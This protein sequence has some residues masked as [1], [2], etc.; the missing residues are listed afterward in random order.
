[1]SEN[2]KRSAMDRTM[3]PGKV[4]KLTSALLLLSL[5][6]LLFSACYGGANTSSGSKM[7]KF[8]IV[9]L[10]DTQVYS[11]KY[12]EIFA[13]QTQWIVEHKDEMN[14]AF[15][16][17]E[18]DIVN[19]NT[20]AE[21]ENA[22]DAMMLLDGV[23]P[24]ALAVGNHDMGTRGVA[25]SRDTTLF[26][27][28][29]PLSR[30]SALPTFGGVFEEDKMDNCYHLFIA[31]GAD[32]LILALEFGPRDQVLEWANNVMA[33]HRDRRAIILT[34]AY[35]YNDNTLHGSKTDH[36]WTPSS[37]GITNLPGGA[38]NGVGIWNKLVSQHKNINFVFSGHVLNSGVGRLVSIG[39][40]GNKIYQMLANY[41][42]IKNGGNGYLRIVEFDPAN[43]E[44]R[45]KTYS[46]LL[47]QYFK[48]D[49]ILSPHLDKYLKLDNF[50]DDAHEF[51]FKNW[52]QA[53]EDETLPFQNYSLSF[54]ERAAD[55]VSRLTLKEK[56]TLLIE[57]SEAIPRLGI[58]RYHFGNE[59]LHG[60]VRPGQFTVFPQ[61]TALASTWNDDIMYQIATAISDEA[62]GKNNFYK[63]D[64]PDRYSGVLT[65]WS[66]DINIARD[67]RWGRTPEAYGE[68][69]HLTSRIAVAFVKGLQGDDPKYI[70]VISTPKHFVAN[71]EEHNRFEC[72]AI[73]SERA[74]R[75]YYLSPFEATVKEANAQSVMAAYNAVNGIPCNANKWLLTDLLRDEWGFDGYVVTDC[76]ALSTMIGNLKYAENR[77]ESAAFALNAGVDLEC[78]YD[79]VFP[80]GIVEALIEGLVTEETISRAV[81]RVLRGRF[82]VGMFDPPEMVPYSKISPN[83][84]GCKKHQDLALRAAQESIVLLKNEKVAGKPLLPLNMENIKSIA[85][86]GPKAGIC[87]FGHYSGTPLNEPVT[88]LQ[89]IKNKAADG[90][91]VNHA[92]WMPD[93]GGLA[94]FARYFKPHA[95]EMEMIKNSDVVVAVLGIGLEEEIE[96]K[97]R[98]DL[99]L[100]D[101]Q[102]NYIK[103]V[104]AVNPRTVVVLINGSPLSVNWINENVPAVVEAW[105]P[106]EQGG[107][108]IADVLF[109]NYNPGGRLPMTFYKSVNDLPPFDDYEISKGRTYMY[110]TNEPLYP[111]GYGLSYTTFQY[112]NLT[113]D[114]KKASESDT[115]TIRVDVKNTGDRDGDEVVQLYVRDVESSIRQPLK[116]LK[117]F[118]RVHIKKGETKTVEIPLAVKDLNF[119]DVNAKRFVV[120]QGEFEILI[121]TSSLDIRM[122]DKI[123]V[124]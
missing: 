90:I 78:G 13:A 46:P 72:N 42:M 102:M 63:G 70:K 33:L 105:Y 98:E 119:W 11:E 86:V 94:R 21:W 79:Y 91:A 24:Y 96:G 117:G 116:Q 110:F 22:R 35:L 27:T 5:I 75:E 92:E 84:I 65:F 100:P 7:E 108:A 45:V 52:A 25:D 120:E 44:V 19:N 18:G 29:F 64:V 34:H 30:Y 115:I 81:F 51:T 49:K 47:N 103:Q 67:P 62:R 23:V 106:G 54:E 38:N 36:H 80:N 71:N 83:V 37:Y 8:S 31:G 14:I 73:I 77:K 88:P 56:I 3:E 109:G 89:G 1:M 60:V 9:I 76:G 99:D 50:K 59:A 107:N 57:T 40:N 2:G 16:L 121:G 74:M 26:N 112:A 15:V 124:K 68:D 28:Y 85:V 10:P 104:L 55:L 4:A 123:T 41:Q 53:D 93:A 82:R 17:H 101:N 6:F 114:K 39:N 122:R 32:W 48:R 20:A 111:F 12:P 87:S 95:A 66:P 69:P 58:P 113:I 61:S 97:D 43:S 118:K